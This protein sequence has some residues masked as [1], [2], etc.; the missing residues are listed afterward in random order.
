ML[1]VQSG[2]IR[3]LLVALS[4]RTL[5]SEDDSIVSLSLPTTTTTHG[6]NTK[7]KKKKTLIESS[8]DK[9]EKNTWHC[10]N[11]RRTN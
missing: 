5:I 9:N 3:R 2:P 4:T 8:A 6:K 7:K 1:M 11:V 10:S